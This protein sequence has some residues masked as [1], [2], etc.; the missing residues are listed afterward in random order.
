MLY[1]LSL[2]W[3][4]EIDPES[5]TLFR[6]SESDLVDFLVNNDQAVVTIEIIQ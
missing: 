2:T 4:G 1:K 3:I 6:E 5:A